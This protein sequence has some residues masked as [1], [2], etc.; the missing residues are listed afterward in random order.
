MDTFT[1]TMVFNGDGVVVS[2]DGKV[3]LMEQRMIV[4][5]LEEIKMDF[6]NRIS[7]K[8]LEKEENTNKNN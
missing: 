6:L 1:I 2:C 5:I 4:S 7:T 3:N 8:N